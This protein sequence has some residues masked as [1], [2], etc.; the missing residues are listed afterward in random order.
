MRQDEA[1]GTPQLH[2]Q[3]ARS[4]L[5]ER[6]AAAPLFCFDGWAPVQDLHLV[7]AQCS[8]STLVA[9]IKLVEQCFVDDA[10]V[11]FVMYETAPKPGDGP[12]LPYFAAEGQVFDT[13]NAVVAYLAREGAP[14]LLEGGNVDPA[15]ITSA[16]DVCQS[17]VVK[18]VKT[19]TKSK[20]AEVSEHHSQSVPTH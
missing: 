7:K 18:A 6:L 1:R 19:A 20:N 5:R 14:H 17:S 10:T 4:R 9:K 11:N 3:P 16:V 2:A 8:N 13:D 12:I 15:A